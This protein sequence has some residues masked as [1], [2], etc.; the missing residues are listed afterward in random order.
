VTRT[1]DFPDPYFTFWSRKFRT[2]N[3]GVTTSSYT[4]HIMAQP[5][6]SIRNYPRASPASGT[7]HEIARGIRPESSKGQVTTCRCDSTHAIFLGLWHCRPAAAR[8][9]NFG[10]CRHY[11][12]QAH[13]AMVLGTQQ[14]GRAVARPPAGPCR[15][16]SI[17]GRHESPPASRALGPSREW[18]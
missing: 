9:Q 11:G 18:S 1:L 14:A 15:C 12:R 5:D 2:H 10:A 7:A 6:L 13:G 8:R 3:R 17:A 4:W 16:Q